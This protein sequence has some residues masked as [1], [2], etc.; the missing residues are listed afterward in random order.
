[1]RV[2]FSTDYREDIVHIFFK[3]S[4]HCEIHQRSRVV[5][6]GFSDA[7]ARIELVLN[8]CPFKDPSA[9]I[10]HRGPVLGHVWLPSLGSLATILRLVVPDVV[11]GEALLNEVT[12]R[13]FQ[14]ISVIFHSKKRKLSALTP[15]N[16]PTNY[17]FRRKCGCRRSHEK[18]ALVVL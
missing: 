17:G 15:N 1:M 5:V 2:V 4:D 6:P 12:G 3:L 10:V 18:N 14:S 13:S 9:Q 7:N 11:L 8:D 16:Q